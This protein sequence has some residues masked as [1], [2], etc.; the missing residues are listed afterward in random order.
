M[1]ALP[2]NI[3]L[4][5]DKPG[6]LFALEQLLVRP[7]RTIHKATSG[8]DGLRLLLKHEFAVVLLDVEMPE[9]DGYET[10]QLMRS[11]ERTRLIPIIFVTAGDPSEQRTFRGYEA[12]AVDFL[13]KPINSH[14]LASKVDIFLELYRSALVIQRTTTSLRERITDLEYVQ[15]TLSHDLRA[16]LRTIRAFSEV[17]AESRDRLDPP[18]VDAL[19]RVVRA[20]A[21]MTTMVE[22]LYGILR[23]SSEEPQAI[24][25][26]LTAVA[27]EVL[28]LLSGDIERIG[29]TVTHD[30]LPTLRTS[31]R[32]VAQ[33][34]QNLVSNALAFRGAQPLAVHI[35]AQRRGSDWLFGI[36]DNGVGIAEVDRE[37]LF[38]LFSRLDHTRSGSGVGL[39]L[40]K[41]AIEKLGGRIWV[42]NDSDC[43]AT[44]YF[45]L[46]DRGRPNAS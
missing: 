11:T 10:A 16:P 32:L 31:K 19:D 26:N 35:S 4:V 8:M 25:T 3:L 46:P 9:M 33:V 40:C 20:A 17:L 41:R 14:V 39:A 7:D 22:D 43:G 1:S 15:Q 12:G 38:K 24:E 6:N 42:G 13:Y 27:R 30:E 23:M 36:R 29:A 5:D 34:L 2:V 18:A 21:R 44:F 37:R 45:T 28:D